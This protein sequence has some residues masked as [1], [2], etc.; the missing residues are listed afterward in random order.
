[1]S[2][3]FT[4]KENFLRRCLAG[5]RLGAMLSV[6]VVVAA[7]ALV[8][9]NRIARVSHAANSIVGAP[10]LHSAPTT[11]PLTLAAPDAI[12][13]ATRARIT[14]TYA[15]LPLAFEANQG[16]FDPQ[17]KYL[18]RGNGYKLYL[19]SSQAVM[20]VSRG[21][22]DSEVR[23]MIE[24]K[25]L[26]PAKIRR[27][28]QERAR[29]TAHPSSL[30]V[31][32]M[33]FLGANPATQLA[34][35]DQQAGRVNYFIG[36]N[37][38]KWRSNIPLFGRV[39]Y[40]DLYPGVDLAFHGAGRQFEFDY[41]VN[42]GA[43]AA[44]IALGFEG[45]EQMSTTSAGDLILT[46]AAGPVQLHKP[47]A[48]QE[49]DGV[50]QL[51]DVRFALKHDHQVAFAL[52]DY[53]R[54]RQLV[55]DPTVT[56]STYF[57]GDFADYG[58]G[59]AADASGDAFIAGATDSDSIPGP[60]GPTNNS[61]FDVFVTE[62][63]SSGTLVFTTLFGGS[64]D[65][66]AGGIAVDA[67]GIYVAGTTSSSDFPASATAAQPTFLGGITHG[68][69]DAF[70]V[71]LA[72]N[73]SAIVWGS[74]I[75]GTDSDSGLAIAVDSTH[76]VFVVGETFSTGLGGGAGVGKFLLP[77]GTAL[78]LGQATGADDG[79]IVALDPNGTSYLLVSYLG[80]S[81][82]D[83]TTGVALDGSGN[84][85]VSGETL[86]TDLPL[87]LPLQN[88]CGTDGT[89]NASALGGPFDDAFIVAIHA[90]LS[91]YIYETYYGGSN[92]DDALA[93][94]ADAAGNAFVT[95]LTVSSDFPTAGTP[96][97][98]ILGAAGAQNAFVLELNSTGSAATYSTY[99]GGSGADLGVGIAIDG[100]D[101]AYVTGQ[102][103]SPDFPPLNP[104]Q[105]TLSGSTDAFVTVL[106]PNPNQLLFSTYLGGGGDE[107]TLSG[108]I[109]VNSLPNIYVTGDTD[110]GNGST[111][112]FPT[113]NPLDGTYGG[114][115][116]TTSTG[117]TIPCPDAFIAAYSPA[118]SPDFALSA[119][120]LSPGSVAQ[121]ASATS[122]VT[123]T[124]LNGYSGTVNLTCNVTGGGSP[125]PKCTLSQTSTKGSGSSTLT[126]HAIGASG[127]LF[128]QN[129]IF[130]ASWL[131]VV[132]LSLLGMQLN[133]A[134]SRRKNLLALLLLGV[135]MMTL[136]FLP[137]CGSSSGGGGGGGCS[138][139]TP[140]GTYAINVTGTDSANASLTH[141]IPT[142]LTLTV[143]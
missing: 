51:V 80:G 111:S 7:A 103:S 75:G 115:T 137:A 76:D 19:T 79:Y 13:P 62:I 113:K 44:T 16:Q 27:L 106:T 36:N 72:L 143:Q 89:C 18:A 66:F 130:Y 47:V 136:L 82:N 100:S 114:G 6:I 71:K 28:L 85:Y 88:K 90:S 40:R 39:S 34:A 3:P 124:A 15:A 133:P 86:S 142:P 1:M 123:V 67:T 78:N 83:L 93:I 64:S 25:R 12:T 127:A 5:I 116:C 65:D 57:G 8:W 35:E 2:K 132:G 128:Q 61:S 24:D 49:K 38:A 101:N 99:L 119:T 53:D 14:A 60:A 104:T 10:N 26:G 121:G 120:P 63:N 29:K 87:T 74:F 32:R 107:D 23:D 95:G 37:P 110:S 73:G 43:D 48:Y 122:T 108:S 68:N 97:Q 102:T 135:V 22:R 98:K 45:A 125:A 46:T 11:S 129:N 21:T 42:P 4:T 109:A 134:R 59:I 96:F 140:T 52:G 126:V 31:V 41:L 138:G 117:S 92:V 139:C 105:A 91:T 94:A 81:S 50:R 84:I 77:N 17:V 112:A 9:G 69:N 118:T 56:Y 33:N 30:A 131:P 55:I 20:T 141:P 70:A 54:N 58:F